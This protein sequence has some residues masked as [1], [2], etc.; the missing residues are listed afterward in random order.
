M[1]K[2]NVNSTSYNSWCC[3]WSPSCNWYSACIC[4]ATYSTNK[5]S[6][7]VALGDLPGGATQTLIFKVSEF[8]VIMSITCL[9][10]CTCPFISKID[11]ENTK[12]LSSLLLQCQHVSDVGGS[13][14][15]HIW[16][17]LASG[18]ITLPEWWYLSLQ[19]CPCHEDSYLI[20]RPSWLK[21]QGDS[22]GLP[23]KNSPW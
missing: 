16:S 7:S 23:G 12:R 13:Q 9:V 1:Y 10:W 3:S 17:Q 19:I 22:T 14:H 15:L 21:V 20:N 18:S 11:H 6:A 4:S 5:G 8:L 2:T